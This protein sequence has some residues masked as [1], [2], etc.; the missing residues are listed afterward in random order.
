M[1]RA[2]TPGRMHRRA[3]FG[4]LDADG[5]GW[6]GVKAGVWLVIIIMLLGYIPDRAYYF[7]VGRT[8]DLGIMFWSPVNLC[9]PENGGLP[10]PP[11]GGSVEPWQLSPSQLDLPEARTGGALAQLGSNVVYAATASILLPVVL[12]LAAAGFGDRLGILSV[13]W[14]WVVGYPLAAGL[15]AQIGLMRLGRTWRWYLAGVA[16]VLGSALAALGVGLLA[17]HLLS[18]WPP[19]ARLAAAAVGG[20]G[21][22]LA[23]VRAV[24]GRHVAAPA[25]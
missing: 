2:L 7:T 4:F 11:P 24:R 10:C 14:G 6:A 16:P 3:L 18:G 23:C 22:F 21:A 15:L 5:W 17:M 9:P 12:V 8:I 25:P 19:A 20:G 1:A 13:A